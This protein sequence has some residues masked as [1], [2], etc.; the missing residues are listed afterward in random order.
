M[1]FEFFFDFINQTPS[2]KVEPPQAAFGIWLSH[3]IGSNKAQ[4]QQ[5]LQQ[6]STSNEWQIQ[7][8]EWQLS[9]ENDEVQLTHHSLLDQSCEPDYLEYEND[10]KIDDQTLQAEAGADDFAHLLQEWAEFI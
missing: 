9:L 7:G 4:L 8:S 2:A 1:N 3:E 5:I 6:L 10:L